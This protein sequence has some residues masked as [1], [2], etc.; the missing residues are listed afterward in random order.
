VYNHKTVLRFHPR[1]PIHYQILVAQAQIQLAFQIQVVDLVLVEQLSIGMLIIL[2]LTQ[3]QL[4]L[5]L[6][7]LVKLQEHIQLH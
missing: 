4:A 2:H 7:Q 3:L 5:R 6:I 1:L